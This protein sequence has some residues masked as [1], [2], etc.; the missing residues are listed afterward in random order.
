MPAATPDPRRWLTLVFVLL[1]GIV[2]VIDSTV[3]NVSVPTIRRELHASLPAVEWVLT[4]Y[5]LTFASLLVIGGRL[6]DLFGARRIAIIGVAVFGIGSLLASVS[7]NVG[8]LIVGEAVIEGI[9]G[10]LLLPSSLSLLTTMFSGH[11]RSN[12]YAAWACALSTGAILGPV[13][14]GYLTTYHSWRWAFRINVV[15]APVVVIALLALGR[16]DEGTGERPRLDVLGMLLITGGAF[17]VVFGISQGTSYG[18]LRPIAA[19]TIA[20][21]S[22]WPASAPVS[23]VPVTILAGLG[24]VLLFVRVE[25]A[26]EA[27]QADPLF[28][29]S[30]FRIKSYSATTTVGGV[31]AFSQLGTALCLALYLQG[32]RHLTPVENGMWVVPSGIAS[33]ISAPLGAWLGRRFDATRVLTFGLAVHATGLVL[34]ALTLPAHLDYVYLLPA[35]IGYGFGNGMAMSQI[36]RVLL[37]D[38]DPAASGAASGMNTTVRQASSAAGIAVSGAVFATATRRYGIDDALAPAMIAACSAAALATVM[39]WRLAP[40]GKEPAGAARDAFEIESIVEAD[41][42]L[43]GIALTLTDR[44]R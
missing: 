26:A 23:V 1:A 44:Q 2:V 8:T 3:L 9:G 19:F 7:T 6:G 41:A 29:I 33:V 22:A 32:S 11:E 30:Q 13:L 25:R 43:G 17:L 15:V 24:L 35:F 12:A 4:G 10:A 27:R 5:S 16:P 40:I 28:A 20:G 14:G 38:I 37:H 31:L 42:Q 21:V 39:G 18:Y 34:L 36:N